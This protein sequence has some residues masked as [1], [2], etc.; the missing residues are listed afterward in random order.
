MRDIIL[1]LKDPRLTVEFTPPDT[2]FIRTYQDGTVIGTLHYKVGTDVGLT[3][4]S[5]KINRLSAT[6]R[7]G[8]ILRITAEIWGTS[9]RTLDTG[10]PWAGTELETA[11]AWINFI[12][13]VATKAAPTVLVPNTKWHE[14]RYEIVNNLERLANVDAKTTRSLERRHRNVTGMLVQDLED[15]AEF[16]EFMGGSAEEKFKMQILEVANPLLG[17][18]SGVYTQW[19]R[20]EA[21][22]GPEDL[23]L[24]RFP[25][26]CL[27][28]EPET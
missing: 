4:T 19:G 23:Q 12:V 27:N 25:F 11:L 3:F 5:A 8:D 26:T 1:G 7:A 2:S 28:I 15:M 16:I 9:V 13:K 17:G 20:I 18:A 6:C 22:H 24:K 14:W 10:C 21:P